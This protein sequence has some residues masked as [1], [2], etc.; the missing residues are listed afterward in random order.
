MPLVEKCFSKALNIRHGA[1]LGVAEILIGLSGNS[2]VNRDELLEEAYKTL[3]KKERKLIAD[4][5]NKKAFKEVYEALSTQDHLR[6]VIA[7]DSEQM[8]VLRGIIKRI[9]KE[10][11]YKGKGGEIM[12]AGVCHLI[13]AM[14]TAKI[15][16]DDS[17]Q[18]EIW[19]TMLENFRH[20]NPEIADAATRA[21]RTF[22]RTYF[23]DSSTKDNL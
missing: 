12:R 20:P 4:S 3:G 10:G 2:I 22:C 21:F 19:E 8:T 13:H 15:A 9:Q 18:S 23:D 11:L 6:K 16:M 14:A 7:D 5:E 1:I 17:L